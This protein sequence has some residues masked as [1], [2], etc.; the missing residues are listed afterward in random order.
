[1][2]HLRIT[3]IVF[4]LM[5]LNLAGGNVLEAETV[6]EHKVMFCDLCVISSVELLG[7]K[8]P[9]PAAGTHRVLR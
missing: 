1:M 8:Q 2:L 4:P 6:R 5:L 7:P 9:L 3:K